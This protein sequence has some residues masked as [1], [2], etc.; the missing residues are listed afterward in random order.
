LQTLRQQLADLQT[1]ARLSKKTYETKSGSSTEQMLADL[2]SHFQLMF[3]TQ[4]SNFESM[5]MKVDSMDNT[6]DKRISNLEAVITPLLSESHVTQTDVQAIVAQE[7]KQ[8]VQI[9][10]EKVRKVMQEKD[11]KISSLE[12]EVQELKQLIEV[13][14]MNQAATIRSPVK[15]QSQDEED[16]QSTKPQ[17]QKS[18]QKQVL[19]QPSNYSKGDTGVASP[20]SAKPKQST[21]SST[22]S[23]HKAAKPP[24]Q[25]KPPQA[26]HQDAKQ[27]AHE[28]VTRNAQIKDGLEELEQYSLNTSEQINEQI[29]GF[30][31]RLVDLDSELAQNLQLILEK[32]QV[33]SSDVEEFISD[34]CEDVREFLMYLRQEIEEVQE[35]VRGRDEKC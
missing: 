19:K 35:Q 28:V 10:D 25:A 7:L 3:E 14:I 31:R 5:K 30:Q 22:Q 29:E 11:K 6:Y 1:E 20:R 4:K 13:G 21:Y 16:V 32:R 9:M 34:L 26:P 23:L 17:T 15:K 8:V 18:G 2:N 27:A 12:S 33:G 24:V